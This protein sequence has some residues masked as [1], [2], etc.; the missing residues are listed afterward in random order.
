MTGTRKV[1]E[2]SSGGLESPGFKEKDE[3][4][5]IQS[6]CSIMSYGDKCRIWAPIK[7]K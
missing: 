4:A 1:D 7:G 3:W 2:S 5:V 6:D